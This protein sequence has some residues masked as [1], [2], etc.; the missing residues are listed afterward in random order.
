MDGLFRDR[1]SFDPSSGRQAGGGGDHSLTQTS[2]CK[3]VQKNSNYRQG[4]V[5]EGVTCPPWPF[6]RWGVQPFALRPAESFVL[7]GLWANPPLF[8]SELQIWPQ[9]HPELL[10][11]SAGGQWLGRSLQ[12]HPRL[13]HGLPL[14]VWLQHLRHFPEHRDL[15]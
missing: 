15:E 6:G 8:S 9:A 7:A 12:P 14:P 2:N 3:L 13:L 5:G 11:L 4:S 1:W 10:L